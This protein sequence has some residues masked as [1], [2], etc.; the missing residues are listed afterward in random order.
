MKDHAGRLR[1]GDILAIYIVPMIIG[2]F[3]GVFKWFPKESGAL[4]TI[5][6][7]LAG[8]SF[9]LAVFVFE[10]RLTAATKF[11]KGSVVLRLIDR[12]FNSVLY[13][14]V[15]GIASAVL[16][17]VATIPADGTVLFR[18]VSGAAIGLSVHYLVGL[19]VSLNRLRKAYVELSR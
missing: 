2:V 9:A 7:I 16:C 10:L 8:L 3:V 1:G 4:L 18:V 14:I 6:S 17:F 19:F 5:I 11:S 13:S 12:L 15:V